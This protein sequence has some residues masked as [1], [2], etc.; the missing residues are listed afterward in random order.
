MHT[1]VMV[2]PGMPVPG[3]TRF[4]QTRNANLR[5]QLQNYASMS[6]GAA[7][8]SPALTAWNYPNPVTSATSVAYALPA[9]GE[10]TLVLCD[11]LGRE[12]RRCAFGAQAPGLYETQIAGQD[13]ALGVH[14]YQVIVRA[15]NGAVH[16]AI[17][18]FT[19]LR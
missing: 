7:P 11:A 19:V 17:G 16:R 1:D 5:T 9:A 10:V 4:S 12:L 6:A 18:K 8:E 3:L 2:G 14:F 15:A 13:L